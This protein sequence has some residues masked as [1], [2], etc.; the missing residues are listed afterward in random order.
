MISSQEIK[1]IVLDLGAQVCG[2]ARVK[3]F[4]QA[5]QGFHPLDIFPQGQSVIVFGKP[6]PQSVFEAKNNCPYTMAMLNLFKE[7]DAIS[8]GFALELEKQGYKAVPIPA[9][10]PY[11]Y[12][13]EENRQG[14]GILSLKHAAQLAGL[15]S[16]GKNT[17]LINEQYGNRLCL[18]AVISDAVLEG[19]SL[20]AEFCLEKCRICLD[21]CPK[22]A[23]DG[24]T[25]QQKK[26]REI[27]GSSTP[28]GG[29]IY[30]CNIC[31][32]VCP[33]GRIMEISEELNQ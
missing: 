17:L 31:R 13:D 8:F 4:D 2:I 14:K 29:F 21:A 10:E 30:S 9:S 6:F 16:I 26:C 15:G 5:P 33:F 23:M 11:E 19:D 32:K 1:K 12:W 7:V 22:Q 18:G 25:V 27:C 24:T 28:G 3:D 20:T